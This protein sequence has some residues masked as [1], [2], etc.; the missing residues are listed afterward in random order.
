MAD[1]VISGNLA[2]IN[3]VGATAVSVN[4]KTNSALTQQVT[5]T[6][7][8]GAINF[9]FTGSGEHNTTIGMATFDVNSIMQASFVYAKPDG[10]W[11]NSA[12]RSGGPYAVGSLN[13]IV[14]VA[15]NGDD[16]DYNDCV[17]QFN[18]R[19]KS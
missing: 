18:W 19:T 2:T 5:L 10:T 14:I 9:V 13:M 6:D 1:V 17:L 3:L 7:K 4:A 8:S 12:L 16:T 11:A 15:E